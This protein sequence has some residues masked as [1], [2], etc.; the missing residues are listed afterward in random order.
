MQKYTHRGVT[1]PLELESERGIVLLDWGPLA[2]GKR[3]QT[4]VWDANKSMP[5]GKRG[6]YRS[7]RYAKEADARQ[8]ATLERAR[9]ITGQDG[10]GRILLS[11]IKEEYLL[12]AQHRELAAKSIGDI[13]R[14]V[15]ELLAFGIDDLKSDTLV[16]DCQRFLKARRRLSKVRKTD[17]L[18][19]RRRDLY[20][21]RAKTTGELATDTRIKLITLIRQI[22]KWVRDTPKFRMPYNPF[23]MLKRPKQDK[24]IPATFM[25]EEMR[26]LVSDEAL[27]TVSGRLFAVLTYTGMRLQEAVWLRWR[28]VHWDSRMIHV[29]LED[30]KPV[31]RDKERIVWVVEELHTLMRS[32]YVA[33]KPEPVKAGALSS[34]LG[35]DFVFPAALRERLHWRHRKAFREHLDGLGIPKGKRSIHKLRHSSACVLLASKTL[36]ALELVEHLGHDE[37]STTRRYTKPVLFYKLPTKGW[38]GQVYLRRPVPVCNSRATPTLEKTPNDSNES[39]EEDSSDYDLVVI[40]PAVTSNSFK[41]SSAPARFENPRVAGSIPAEATTPK[42]AENQGFTDGGDAEPIQPT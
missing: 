3:Y 29:V 12:D 17:K 15:T 8:Q 27:A 9:F 39:K 13:E 37:E 18:N 25:V 24:R 1:Y 4:R 6:G 33:A 2:P 32:W 16:A 31:K 11:R 23:E 22:G 21:E 41:S 19:T 10:A 38:D 35:D 36:D 26:K 40:L 30:G 7:T 42:T 34:V 14:T 28:D 5:G 20:R